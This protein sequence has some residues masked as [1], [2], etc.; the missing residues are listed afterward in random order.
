MSRTTS[1]LAFASLAIALTS[2]AATTNGGGGYYVPQ[3]ADAT[4]SGQDTAGTPADTTGSS[5]LNFGSAQGQWDILFSNF[6]YAS[7]TGTIGAKVADLTLITTIEGQAMPD[8]YEYPDC[9]FTKARSTLHVEFVNETLALGSLTDIMENNGKCKNSMTSDSETTNFTFKRDAPGISN[10]GT[11]A[12]TWHFEYPGSP[13]SDGFDT[14]CTFT[15]A[16]GESQGCGNAQVQFSSNLVGTIL[17]GKIDSATID[18]ATFSAQ[19]K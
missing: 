2:C 18:S 19:R 14:P 1:F 9:V 11:A 16:A 7:G 10:F 17:N 8:Y 6:H 4:T 3:Q 5:T 15:I 12:G 13:V